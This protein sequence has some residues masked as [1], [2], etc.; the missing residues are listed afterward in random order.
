MQ[1]N[2]INAIC[3]IVSCANSDLKSNVSNKSGIFNKTD[4]LMEDYIKDAIAGS[5]Q[6]PINKKMDFYTKSFSYLG[7]QNNPPHIIVKNGDA[8]EIRKIKNFNSYLTLN[9]PTLRNKLLDSDIRI[10]TA[11]KN[12]ESKSWKEKDLFYTVVN[13]KRKNLKYLFFIQG[14]CY[15]AE[16]KTYEKNK[17]RLRNIKS[18]GS[19]IYNLK[20]GKTKNPLIYFKEHLNPSPKKFNIYAMIETKKYNSFPK[21]DRENLEKLGD[22]KIT[23]LKIKSPNDC[24]YA[25]NVK[26]ISCAV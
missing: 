9:G 10:T 12:C 2:I 16:P 6:L 14:V 5:F 21:K 11:C 18:K 3:N 24:N 1:K 23:D 25:M 22:V 8:F 26:L 13:T 7:N 15:A 17:K 20:Y 4:D 19:F